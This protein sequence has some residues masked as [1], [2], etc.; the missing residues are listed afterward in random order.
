MRDKNYARMILLR[1]REEKEEEEEEEGDRGTVTTMRKKKE[2]K[3][4]SERERRI[5]ERGK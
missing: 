3:W 5:V 1:G 4:G 2:I